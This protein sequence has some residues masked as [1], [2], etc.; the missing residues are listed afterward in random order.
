MSFTMP[1][2]ATELFEEIL[3][4][5][6]VAH[7]QEAKSLGGVYGIKLEGPAAGE[8]TINLQK[9]T[10]S[11]EKGL[12]GAQCT[13]LLQEQD[14]F[15]LL[16]NPTM[17]MNLFLQGKIKVEGNSMLALKIQKLLSLGRSSESF[18]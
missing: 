4:K 15:A 17:A 11:V 14:F 5:L 16:Q 10:P 12:H 8:W 1:T 2:S 6:L 3:P 7:A 18:L 9:E 13:V